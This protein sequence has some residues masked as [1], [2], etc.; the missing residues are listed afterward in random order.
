MHYV[1]QLCGSND[2]WRR[3]VTANNLNSAV[4]K[5]IG[6]LE[7]DGG[8]A[9]LHDGDSYDISLLNEAGGLSYLRVHVVFKPVLRTEVVHHA[10]EVRQTRIDEI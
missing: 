6:Q 8:V 4:E 5:Y 2:G 3:D 9:A 1:F 7:N 10:P